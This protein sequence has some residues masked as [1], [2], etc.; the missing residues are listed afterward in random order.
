MSFLHFAGQVLAPRLFMQAP[1]NFDSRPAAARHNWLQARLLAHPWRLLALLVGILAPLAV[2]ARLADKVADKEVLRF[3]VP[4][5][6]WLHA[7]SNPIL[8][9]LFVTISQIGGF[10]GTAV[11]GILGAW[12]LWRQKR[13]RP[14]WFWGLSIGGSGA[15]DMLV[16]LFFRRDRPTLW[17]SIAPEHDYSFPSGHSMLSASV[18][19]SVLLLLWPTKW[20][21]P[22]L[23]LALAWPI[24]VGLSRLYIG[25]HFP[26]D[27]LAG[28]CS[29]LAWTMGIYFILRGERD[30]FF[31]RGARSQAQS[32]APLSSPAHSR[33]V[34]AAVDGA[35]PAASAASLE[36]LGGEKPAQQKLLEASLE[37]SREHEQQ[38]KT[39]RQA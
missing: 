30:R 38:E 33:Q 13:I 16:K 10:P 11:I 9:H 32:G 21:W 19:L 1:S 3:D 37:A 2:A 27:V 18:A 39:Q 29:G 36:R 25:V 14:G 20:R 12:H 5:L 22:A 26:S 23:A 35:A 7:R 17:R 34:L 4:I 8:D 15:L 24:L 28:W 6:L 31:K